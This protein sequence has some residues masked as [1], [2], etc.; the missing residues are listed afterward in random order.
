MSTSSPTC[1]P[2]QVCGPLSQPSAELCLWLPLSPQPCC[3]VPAEPG[4]P[5]PLCWNLEKGQWRVWKLMRYRVL[6]SQV[7]GTSFTCQGRQA[8]PAVFSSPRLSF[9]QGVCVQQQGHSLLPLTHPKSVSV[10]SALSLE[11]DSVTVAGTSPGRRNGAASLQN[12]DS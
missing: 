8:L 1:M 5:F 9:S 11:V 4:L 3:L 12:K 6:V 2:Y 7:G 10:V